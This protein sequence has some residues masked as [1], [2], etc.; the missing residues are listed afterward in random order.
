[1][2]QLDQGGLD[3]ELFDI[4]LDPAGNVLVSGSSA[5]N[6]TGEDFLTAKY[7]RQ[8][9][10]LWGRLYDGPGH[11]RDTGWNVTSDRAGQGAGG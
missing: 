4:A 8:G 11:D 6:G 5:S 1:M 3:D 7:D 10:L 9:H 2:R